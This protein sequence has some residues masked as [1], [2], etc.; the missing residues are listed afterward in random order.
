M[1]RDV[2]EIFERH[3]QWRQAEAERLMETAADRM[4]VG[5]KIADAHTWRLQSGIRERTKYA[6]GQEMIQYWGFSYGTILGATLAAM[7]PERIS[8]ALLDGVADSHDY[9]AGGTA[10]HPMINITC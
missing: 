2:V 4:L 3:G 6:P 10:T 1:A 5:R 8:R 7:Y 9:M